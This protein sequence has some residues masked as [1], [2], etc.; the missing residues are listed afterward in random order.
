[1]F[2]PSGPP[3]SRQPT[4]YSLQ[5]ANHSTIATY[6]TRSLT[7]DLGFRHTFRWVFIMADV[8]HAILGDDFLHH[9]G[10]TVDIQKSRLTDE[11]IQLQVFGIATTTTPVSPA[12]PNLNP[13]DPYAA[14]LM[15]FPNILH[16]RTYDQPCQHSITHHIRTTGQ[17]V[18]ARPRHLP[19]DRLK[20]AKREICHQTD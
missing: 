12:L 13:Q 1:M 14:V 4:G 17:P 16:L 19:P 20:V 18:S 8:K 5:A 11:L 9:F 15:G 2:P 3:H 6:E 10:L 7:L